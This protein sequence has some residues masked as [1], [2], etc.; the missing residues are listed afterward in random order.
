MTLVS[1]WIGCKRCFSRFASTKRDATARRSPL[2]RLSIGVTATF[3]LEAE[4][5]RTPASLISRL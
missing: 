5:V 3:G 1:L 4:D 2:R